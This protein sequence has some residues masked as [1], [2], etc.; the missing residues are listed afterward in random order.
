MVEEKKKIDPVWLEKVSKFFPWP[1][2]IFEFLPKD[3]QKKL[4]VK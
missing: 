4:V 1:E 3:L 2:E